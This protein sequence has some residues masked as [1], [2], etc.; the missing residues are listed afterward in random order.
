MTDRAAGSERYWINRRVLPQLSVLIE[1]NPYR[2]VSVSWESL[3]LT[4]V[5]TVHPRH[6]FWGYKRLYDWTPLYEGSLALGPFQFYL[7]F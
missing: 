6:W 5:V 7:G 4:A 2:Q 1:R 3:R